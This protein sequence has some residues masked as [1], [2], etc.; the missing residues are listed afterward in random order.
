MT[1]LYVYHIFLMTDGALRWSPG[2]QFPHR[3]YAASN[4]FACQ[5]KQREVGV[6]QIVKQPARIEYAVS[7]TK[8]YQ[9]HEY[10]ISK[11]CV[12]GAE[13]LAVFNWINRKSRSFT[14]PAISII[15]FWAFPAYMRVG[16]YCKAPRAH[17]RHARVALATKPCFR[18]LQKRTARKSSPQGVTIP[19]AIK[20]T[21]IFIT[22]KNYFFQITLSLDYLFLQKANTN[23]KKHQEI[24]Q[25]LIYSTKKQ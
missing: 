17:R 6:K 12:Q 22:H 13:V 10:T 9:Y 20:K 5:A 8:C 21:N 2:G 16:L 1:R 3:V 25:H 23:Y 15:F 7:R 11:L 4:I 14:R 18:K 19:N 24:E